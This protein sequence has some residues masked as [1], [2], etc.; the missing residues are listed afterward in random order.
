[1]KNTKKASLMF[2]TALKHDAEGNVEACDKWLDKAC[3]AE[4]AAVKTKEDMS[5]IVI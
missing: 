1:M 5:Q 2:K 3:E 4:L